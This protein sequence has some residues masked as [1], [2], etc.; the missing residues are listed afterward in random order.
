M[1]PYRKNDANLTPQGFS[2]CSDKHTVQVHYLCYDLGG[3]TDIFSKQ[4]GLTYSRHETEVRTGRLEQDPKHMEIYLDSSLYET[5]KIPILEFCARQ[6][7]FLKILREIAF[8]S[9]G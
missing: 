3:K 6:D 5:F 4:Q 9:R 8:S 1:G 2:L 7:Y